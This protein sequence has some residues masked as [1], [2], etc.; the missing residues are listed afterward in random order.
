MVDS[1]PG[2]VFWISESVGCVKRPA[3]CAAGCGVRISH[4]G[5]RCLECYQKERLACKKL[6]MPLLYACAGGCGQMQRKDGRYCRD[7]N[8]SRQDARAAYSA[9]HLRLSKLR[10][11]LDNGKIAGLLWV[12]PDEA[13]TLN[14]RCDRCDKPILIGS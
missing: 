10:K 4:A 3:T 2:S 7:C 5:R 14:Y 9:N 8:K 6:R 1:V 12:A 11:S 13:W